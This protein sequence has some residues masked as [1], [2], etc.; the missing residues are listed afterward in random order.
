M[1]LHMTLPEPPRARAHFASGVVARTAH[2]H[3]RVVTW[4]LVLVL[5][6]SAISSARPSASTQRGRKPKFEEGLASWYG[7]GFHGKRTA[8]GEIYD[9]NALTAAHRTLP[10][11]TLVE[12]RNLENDR[13]LVA[14]INDRGP[15]NRRRIL[16][17][18]MAAAKELGIDRTGI[19]RV[20][21]TVV[22]SP[23]SQ[24]P[25]RYWVQVGAFQ[26]EENA[27]ALVADLE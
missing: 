10:L 2:R 24:A 9:M 23:G 26:E 15:H 4:S 22:A 16:D 8:S 7:P 12:V 13:T 5:A 25:S 21:L 6:G 20:R 19:A 27:R 3:P 1:T 11:G 17:L 18:S 14:R